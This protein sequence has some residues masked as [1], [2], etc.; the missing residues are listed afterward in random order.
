MRRRDQRS[1]ATRS[2]GSKRRM[3]IETNGLMNGIGQ[4]LMAGP[5]SAIVPRIMR[6]LCVAA[7][8]RASKAQ[9]VSSANTANSSRSPTKS[10]RDV[11]TVAANGVKQC[12]HAKDDHQ[13]KQNRAA[14]AKR[15]V[16][17]HL[18]CGYQRGLYYH[19]ED[20]SDE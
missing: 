13:R 4:R 3:L 17:F 8:R 18:V 9:E 12:K 1:Y 16:P 2:S 15:H 10:R 5:R 11:R 20:P 14:D 19:E 6:S 7:S